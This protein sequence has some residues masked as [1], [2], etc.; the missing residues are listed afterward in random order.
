MNM[1]ELCFNRRVNPLFIDG[2]LEYIKYDCEWKG[3]ESLFPDRRR[4]E[5]KGYPGLIDRR[6]I[7]E[8]TEFFQDKKGDLDMD[9]IMEITYQIN[10]VYYDIK[11]LLKYF[12][13]Q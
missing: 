3:G 11:P 6:S 5:R 13:R 8:I 2:A 1:N 10:K 9:K 4:R 7:H 12:S